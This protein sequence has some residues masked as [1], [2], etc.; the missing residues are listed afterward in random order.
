MLEDRWLMLELGQSCDIL[1]GCELLSAAAEYKKIA[2]TNPT[3]IYFTIV[4]WRGS[5]VAG[6]ETDQ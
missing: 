2:A 4:I 3:N 5:A 1:H 6:S